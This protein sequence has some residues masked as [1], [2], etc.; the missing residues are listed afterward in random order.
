MSNST[1]SNVRNE[2]KPLMQDAQA[3][4]DEAADMGDAKAAELRTKAMKT[5]DHAISRANELQES[6]I[7]KGRKIAKDTDAYVH[8]KPWRVIGVAGTVGLLI[9]MLIVRR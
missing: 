7:R 5:L 8:E 2:L 4:L 6:A 3:L 1:F 9:G